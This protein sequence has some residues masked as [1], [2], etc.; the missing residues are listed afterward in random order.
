MLSFDG[1]V[2]TQLF[3]R[4]ASDA[5]VK[6]I[7]S[8]LRQRPGQLPN[9][10]HHAGVR[11]VVLLVVLVPDQH[12]ELQVRPA[13]ALLFSMAHPRAFSPCSGARRPRS[14]DAKTAVTDVE[15]KT[16]REEMESSRTAGLSQPPRVQRFPDVQYLLTPGR[17]HPNRPQEATKIRI[18]P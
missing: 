10:R 16:V 15:K 9:L 4:R 1:L 13:P 6:T 12:V 5:D 14:I 8:Y 17:L 11:G 18:S 2:S 3:S 7:S